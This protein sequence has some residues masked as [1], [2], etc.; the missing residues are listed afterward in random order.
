MESAFTCT[1]KD[2]LSQHYHLQF[3]LFVVLLLL[4]FFSFSFCQSLLFVVF[5]TRRAFRESK[6][7]R[8]D[9]GGFLGVWNFP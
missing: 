7:W 3:F 4:E 2:C 1:G 9:M 6:T 5:S 8:F